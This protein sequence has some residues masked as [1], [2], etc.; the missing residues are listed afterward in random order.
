MKNTLY[1]INDI[2]PFKFLR[3]KYRMDDQIIQLI[4]TIASPVNVSSPFLNW[5]NIKKLRKAPL[6]YVNT[7]KFHQGH[8]VLTVEFKML[9]Y[10]TWDD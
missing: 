8:R 4:F 3:F 2:W 1:L 6:D 7:L 9:K 10:R 5:G